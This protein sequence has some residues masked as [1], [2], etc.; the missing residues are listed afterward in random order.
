MHR[1]YWPLVKVGKLLHHVMSVCVELEAVMSGLFIH[2][3]INVWLGLLL[4]WRFTFVIQGAILRFQRVVHKDEK[5]HTN[6]DESYSESVKEMFAT[7]TLS[8]IE[9]RRWFQAGIRPYNE[10]QSCSTIEKY[11]IYININISGDG[12]RPPQNTHWCSDIRTTSRRS[13]RR[14][15]GASW[16]WYRELTEIRGSLSC[17]WHLI[18]RLVMSSAFIQGEA[19]VLYR[20]RLLWERER[21]IPC[22]INSMNDVVALYQHSIL[23]YEDLIHVKLQCSHFDKNLRDWEHQL[24][25]HWSSD[26]NMIF[27]CW[28][29]CVWRFIYD[30]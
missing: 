26:H 18:N 24:E 20:W 28:G 4:A 9:R 13:V 7:V 15:T 29:M 11:D 10:Y 8:L 17:S 12:E 5:F 6:L 30:E 2:Q 1:E 27:G 16:E 25:S 3:R 22:A 19:N 23:E 14:M 21:D